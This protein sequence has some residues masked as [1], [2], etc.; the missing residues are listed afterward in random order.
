M[1]PP[2]IEPQSPRPLADIVQVL[3]SRGSII[4]LSHKKS[5]ICIYILYTKSTN[6]YE[7]NVEFFAWIKN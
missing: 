7:N 2:G 5:L 4:L 1:T 3:W 6:H